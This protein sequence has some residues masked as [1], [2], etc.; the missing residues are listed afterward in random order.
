MQEEINRTSQR[1]EDYKLRQGEVVKKWSIDK[2]VDPKSHQCLSPK[3]METSTYR[4][5][6]SGIQSKFNLAN[7]V[8]DQQL[9]EQ[10]SAKNALL[11]EMAS[12]VF[13]AQRLNAT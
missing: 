13:P 1:L 8:S 12:S 7:T 5:P 9:K 11:E 10:I 3:S 2:N 4:A 6:T